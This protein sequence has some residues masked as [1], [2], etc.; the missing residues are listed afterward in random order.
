MRRRVLKLVSYVQTDGIRTVI[1]MVYER[2]EK[3][4]AAILYCIREFGFV[5]FIK[6]TYFFYTRQYGKYNKLNYSILVNESG[7]II[8]DF[9]KLTKSF[10]DDKRK[11]RVWVCWWQGYDK[12]PEIV[13]MCYDHMVYTLDGKL[14]DV[15]LITEEN[16]KEYVDIPLPVVEKLQQGKITLTLFSDILRQGL[17]FQN[18]G[19]WIDSTIWVEKDANKYL[20]FDKDFWSVKLEEIDD[21]NVWGQLI[22]ECKWCGFLIGAKKDNVICGFTFR[23]MCDYVTKH[24]FVVDYFMQNLFIKIAYDMIPKVSEE[25]DE[26]ECSNPNLYELFRYL[27]SAYSEN[28]YKSIMKDTAIFKLT[29]KSSLYEYSPEGAITTY[30]YLRQRVS[31][32]G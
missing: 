18:G 8:H 27:N 10:P 25:I 2:L 24:N 9:Q 15:K 16:F 11:K 21:K 7:H 31:N 17:L 6:R 32:E 14:F 12:M 29:Y 1:K 4:G 13:K 22:T 28:L 19:I 20:S 26:I 30:G 5:Y 3:W 23:A